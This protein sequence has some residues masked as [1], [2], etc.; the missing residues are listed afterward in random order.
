[1]KKLLALSLITGSLLAA[2]SVVCA[3]DGAALFEANCA[4]CHGLDGKGATKMGVKVGCKDFTDAAYQATITDEKIAKA[5]KEG[6]KDGDKTKMKA[7]PDLSA[8]DV[9][10]LT[11]HVHSFKK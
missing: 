5:L 8:D 9:T 1:M 6:V 2:T 11:A 4:K 10:A 7:F 3:A